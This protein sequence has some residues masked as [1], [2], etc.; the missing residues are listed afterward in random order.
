MVGDRQPLAPARLCRGS[1]AAVVAFRSAVDAPPFVNT[2]SSTPFEY[3]SG[4]ATLSIDQE[5]SPFG[6]H[7]RSPRTRPRRA[8]SASG[9]AARPCRRSPGST[10]RSPGD[11]PLEVDLRLAV[12]WVRAV[13]LRS[14]SPVPA[15]FQGRTCPRSPSSAAFCARLGKRLPAV[16]DHR[17]GDVRMHEEK[18]RIH[19]GLGVPEDEAAVVVAR[20]ACR[21]DAVVGARAD[22]GPAA[23]TGSSGPSPASRAAR[24]TWMSL[25]HRSPQALACAPRE[26]L[27]PFVAAAA[28]RGDG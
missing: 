11:V 15:P 1:A 10:A 20:Q 26:P 22:A 14:R 12:R 19:P 24:P 4:P 6:C 9:R 7:P 13:A 16:R 25:F 18:A 3:S 5:P 17:I 8:G 2:P 28:G 21:G 23:R 27:H